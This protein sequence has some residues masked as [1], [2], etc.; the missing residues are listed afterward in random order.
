MNY[1]CTADIQEYN[2]GCFT[3]ARFTAAEPVGISAVAA[4]L[5]QSWNI[6]MIYLCSK[7]FTFLHALLA[8]MLLLFINEAED[9]LA[10]F[11]AG[12]IY[13]SVKDF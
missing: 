6:V 10:P 9:R 13:C 8:C 7:T 5:A 1:E 4:L 2:A 3:L 11:Y 12:Q